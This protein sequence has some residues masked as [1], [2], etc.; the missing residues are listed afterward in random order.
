MHK[1][2]REILM[3]GIAA[4]DPAVAL[5]TCV[6]VVSPSTLA[7]QNRLFYH[8]KDFDHVSII[9]FGKAAVPMAFKVCE[10]VHH[11][12]FSSKNCTITMDGLVITKDMHC[13]EKEQRTLQM[14]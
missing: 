13:T 8:A 5:D 12:F 10:L 9:S 11:A 7:V 6:Q 2:A 4:V 1:D 14:S 3:A